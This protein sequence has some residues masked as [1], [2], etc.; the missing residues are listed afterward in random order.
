MKEK[1]VKVRP[2]TSKYRVRV[3]RSP[4]YP[5]FEKFWYLEVFDEKISNKIGEVTYRPTRYSGLALT[6]IGLKVA[7]KKALKKAGKTKSAEF[8]YI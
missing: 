4:M 8:I 7:I 2:P 6:K 5:S 1:K 3:E